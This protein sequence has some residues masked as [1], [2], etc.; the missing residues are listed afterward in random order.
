MAQIIINMK[1]KIEYDLSSNVEKKDCYSCSDSR[2]KAYSG[3]KVC[4]D[5]C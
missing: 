5:C 3:V 1:E 4:E 2:Q